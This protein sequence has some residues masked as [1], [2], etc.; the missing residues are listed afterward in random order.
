MHYCDGVC[1]LEPSLGYGIVDRIPFFLFSSLLSQWCSFVRSLGCGIAD[2]IYFPNFFYLLVGS[3]YG[4]V[5]FDASR[6][7]EK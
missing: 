6:R 5:Q 2:R 4:I 3:V 1:S 7:G